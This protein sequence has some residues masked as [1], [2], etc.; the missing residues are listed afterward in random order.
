MDLPPEAIGPEG[1]IASR[2]GSI[3]ERLSNNKAT[4]DFP[5]RL[6]SP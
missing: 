6:P 4:C 1:P 3:P 2:R 5:G